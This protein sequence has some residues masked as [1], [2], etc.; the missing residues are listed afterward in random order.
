MKTK[1]HPYELIHSDHILNLKKIWKATPIP[2]VL[3][4]DLYLH[5]LVSCFKNNSALVMLTI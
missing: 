5:I 1:D 3:S 4:Y 2:T